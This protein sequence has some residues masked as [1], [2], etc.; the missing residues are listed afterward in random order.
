[1]RSYLR[2]LREKKELS[3]QQLA[4]KLGISQNYYCMIETGERQKRL[5]IDMARRLADALG[6][7]LEYICQQEQG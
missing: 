3:Q 7:T 6:T 4:D 2:E 5:D 1:M